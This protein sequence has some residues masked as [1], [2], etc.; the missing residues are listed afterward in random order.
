MACCSIHP[1]SYFS[2]TEIQK[3]GGA[4]LCLGRQ[5]RHWICPHTVLDFDQ[6]ESYLATKRDAVQACDDYLHFIIMLGHSMLVLPFLEAEDGVSYPK[7]FVTE[8][9]KRHDIQVCPHMRL[10]DP[11]VLTY[12]SAQ[13][14]GTAL[15]QCKQ[16][17]LELRR[18]AWHKCNT[19][20]MFRTRT[21]YGRIFQVIVHRLIDSFRGPVDPAWIALLTS[22]SDFVP[23]EA[24]WGRATRSV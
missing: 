10:S 24:E 5:G 11:A 2:A 17:Y 21:Y 13:C 20:V 16:R 7:S 4:R 22:R 3:Y 18:R 15:C 1:V 12:L 23:L 6:F 8:A 19:A 14:E 9:L